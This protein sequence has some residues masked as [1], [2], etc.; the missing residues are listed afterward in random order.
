[1]KRHKPSARFEIRSVGGRRQYVFAQRHVA[2]LGNLARDFARR[3]DTAVTRLRA[4]R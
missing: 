4:L 1:M 2:D 3:Q